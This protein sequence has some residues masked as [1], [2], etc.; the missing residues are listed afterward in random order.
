MACS[1]RSP[2]TT[3]SC[4]AGTCAESTSPQQDTMPISRHPALGSQRFARSCSTRADDDPLVKPDAPRPA[5]RLQWCL[6]RPAVLG[7]GVGVS[8]FPGDQQYRSILPGS[9]SDPGSPRTLR[10]SAEVSALFTTLVATRCAIRPCLWCAAATPSTTYWQVARPPP[11]QPPLFPTPAAAPTPAPHLRTIAPASPAAPRTAHTTMAS[12][13]SRC[14]G[15]AAQQGTAPSPE[16]SR[17]PCSNRDP[18]AC[19]PSIRSPPT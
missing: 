8:E 6:P 1:M 2:S 18:P 16:S 13:R 14:P 11:P 5:T 17:G 12:S 7:R 10:A 4:E 3:S 15:T 19:S 9:S